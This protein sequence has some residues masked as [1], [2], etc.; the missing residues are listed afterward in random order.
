MGGRWVGVGGE[1][2]TPARASAGAWRP[3]GARGVATALRGHEGGRVGSAWGERSWEGAE[4]GG[5]AAES[6]GEGGGERER[7]EGAVQDGVFLFSRFPERRPQ[8]CV[9]NSGYTR[10]SS[11]NEVTPPPALEAGAA[12]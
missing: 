8:G 1:E 4:G 7:G 3:S 11:S 9:G 5:Q 12:A 2:V 10:G 6:G